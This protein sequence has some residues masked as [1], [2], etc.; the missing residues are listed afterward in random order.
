M[1]AEQTIDRELTQRS[2]TARRP[3]YRI[4][5]VEDEALIALGLEQILLLQG[6]EV[7]A[8]A[9]SVDEAVD[10]VDRH[11]PDLVLMD[12][13]LRGGG[14]GVE[15]ADRIWKRFGIRSLFTSAVDANILRSRAP[16][17][18]LGFITKPYRP[19]DFQRSLGALSLA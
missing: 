14:D 5:V 11:R 9:S 16:S 15:A 3:R 2:S 10:A 8:V 13:M 18:S 19:E 17:V 7:C 12:V 1:R 6:H 4:V